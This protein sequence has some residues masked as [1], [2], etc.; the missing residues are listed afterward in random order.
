MAN[1]GMTMQKYKVHVKCIL[2]NFTYYCEIDE[3]TEFWCGTDLTLVFAGV[4]SFHRP[5]RGKSKLLRV[6]TFHH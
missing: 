4:G 6:M 2:L 1:K 3:M 5:E